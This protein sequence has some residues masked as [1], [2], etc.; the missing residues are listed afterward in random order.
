MTI[1]DLIG[2]YTVIGAN[3]DDQD[4][5]YKG[6]LTL[7]INESNQILAEW[8][9][10]KNQKQIGIGFFK[11]NVLV[12][13]FQYVGIDAEIYKG[14]VVYKCISKDVLDGFWSEELGDPNYLGTELCYLC[15]N[16]WNLL[17]W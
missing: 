8:T 15:R 12:I 5:S 4:I 16:K 9:I 10:H 1:Q 6:F 2:N 7:S 3:Q 11:D 14:T 13:N 17:E